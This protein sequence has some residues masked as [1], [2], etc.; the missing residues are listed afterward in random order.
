MN[1]LS[2]FMS[3][4]CFQNRRNNVYI[5]LLTKSVT[6]GFIVAI[7]WV[8]RLPMNFWLFVKANCSLF[9]TIIHHKW[10]ILWLGWKMGLGFLHLIIHDWSKFTPEEWWGYLQKHQKISKNWRKEDDDRTFLYHQNRNPHHL[11]YWVFIEKDTPKPI[12]IPEMFI[13]E[14]VVDWVAANLAYSHS[15]EWLDQ[16]RQIKYL[17]D[18]AKLIHPLSKPKIVKEIHRLARTLNFSLEADMKTFLEEFQKEHSSE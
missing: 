16:K 18:H 11:E 12:E 13:T 9:F 6:V 5:T 15:S 14:M 10:V 2:V 8:F 7:L 1:L 17:K 4:L 3:C